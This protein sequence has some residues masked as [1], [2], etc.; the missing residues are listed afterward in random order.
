VLSDVFEL[1]E[2]ITRQVVGSMVP[3]IEAEEMRLLE[4]GQRRFSEADEISW[5]AAK[6]ATDAVFQG[7][8]ALTLEAIRL[9]EQAIER[10][11]NCRLAWY[12]LGRSH[13][14]RVFFAWTQDR[15]GSLGAA[16]RAAEML[17]TLAPN[18]SRSYFLRGV[19]EV[20][21]GDSARGA[22][23][24]RR[25]LELNPNDAAIL[26]I[27]SFT[28]AS[29]GFV[30]RAKELAAQALRM[31]PKDRSVG[32]AHLAYA[33]SAFIEQDFTRLREWA[34]LAIQSHPGAPIRRVLMIAY[35]AEVG[36]APL[37]RTHLEK[38]QSVAPDFIPSLFRGDYRPFHKPEHMKM[39][40]DSLRKA[41]LAS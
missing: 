3:E 21:A 34:E 39:L 25:A 19:V 28:E 17:M 33:M 41:G 12:V 40:L 31:S 23:N 4:R 29:A 8:P 22:A 15:G 9:A 18:D 38:V 11:R 6:A 36:D 2:R 24:L 37:L 13:S 1:Q 32:A 35:A 26:F 20:F 30:D 14:W 7:Q 5:R 16:R 27:L 10:D